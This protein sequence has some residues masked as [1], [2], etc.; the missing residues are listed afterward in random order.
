[1]PKQLNNNNIFGDVECMIAVISKV[2][3]FGF[4]F[5]SVWEYCLQQIL[6]LYLNRRYQNGYIKELKELHY[7]SNSYPVALI[8]KI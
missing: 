8:L 7:K 3:F 5:Q 4:Q 1:M 6:N 2:L